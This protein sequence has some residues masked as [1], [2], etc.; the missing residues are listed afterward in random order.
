MSFIRQYSSKLQFAITAT[1][2]GNLLQW[3]DFSLF[4]MMLPLFML[5]FFPE[6]QGSFFFILYAFGACARPLG[7]LFFGYVGDTRGRKSALVKTILCMTLPILLVALLPSH[8][9]I[10]M[11]SGILLGIIY[12]FQGFC[13][14]GEF[15]GSIVFLTESSPPKL[16]T[17]V[18]SWSYFGVVLGMLLVSLDIFM[19]EQSLT[20]EALTSWGWRLPFFVGAVIG[21]IGL[22]MRRFL[23][24][25]PVFQEARK[26]GLLVQRPLMDT[27]RKEKVRLLK[28]F[29]IYL[30]DAI[31]FN[32]IIIFS[33][34]YYSKYIGLSLGECFRLNLFTVFIVLCFIPIFGK[35][36]N[37]MGTVR[38]ARWASLA[39]FVF[40]FPLYSLIEQKSLF[41]IYLAQGIL[42]FIL[43][44]YVS[45]MP[46]ILYALFPTRVR[47]TCVGI[48]VN[49][50]VALFGGT[51]PLIAHTLI[52]LTKYPILPSFYL[53]SGALVSFF[54]LRSFTPIEKAGASNND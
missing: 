5:L 28:G 2:L 23:H 7:G 38:L 39:L 6:E 46:A 14:G 51:A 25:T 22:F 36:G 54:C 19:M 41:S 33:N 35:I 53:M 1:V 16:R 34:Y 24:E 13:V 42:G 29:G 17:F 32:L 50:S 49:F 12:L 11:A 40:A 21:M 43:T 31:G 27:F 52:D 9:Q 48:V 30:T 8:K 44:A 47:Y 4:G 45:N 26:E 15:P 18:G 20:K 37:F 10:G 3:F